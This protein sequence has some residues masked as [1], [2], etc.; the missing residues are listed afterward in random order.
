MAYTK[1]NW[2]NDSVPAI[3]ADNLNKIEQGIYE[4]HENT[5]LSYAAMNTSR[6]FI[7]ITNEQKIT[8]WEEPLSFGD[9]TADVSNDRIVIRNTEIVEVSGVSGGNG[10]CIIFYKIEDENGNNIPS[11]FNNRTL[12]NYGDVYWAGPLKKA[13]YTLDPTKVY[14]LTL[15]ADKYQPSSYFAMNNGFGKYA[16]YL[17][18]KKLK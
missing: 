18:A 4:V 6:D 16:T 10:R 3:N 2:I 9:Y 12:V 14:Y 11:L 5:K 13:I 8:G 17:E 15:Y 1:T 7:E